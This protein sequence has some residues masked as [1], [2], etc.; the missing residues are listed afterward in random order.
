MYSPS[1]AISFSFRPTYYSTQRLGTQ[2]GIEVPSRT[3]GALEFSGS[4][5]INI[6]VG[7]KGTLRGDIGRTYTATRST[8]FSSGI[9]EASPRGEVE[10]WNGS[11][12]LTWNF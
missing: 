11:L 3:D 1:P 10:H 4:A 9:P 7:R 2:N 8:T 6:P 5:N 12:Q